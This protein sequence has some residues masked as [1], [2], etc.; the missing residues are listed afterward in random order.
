ML[1]LYKGF[2]DVQS[3]TLE[4]AGGDHEF[5]CVQGQKTMGRGDIIKET[6]LRYLILRMLRF[7]MKFQW[8]L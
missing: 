8:Y 7:G 5:A 6:T 3:V 2:N 4:K 1:T